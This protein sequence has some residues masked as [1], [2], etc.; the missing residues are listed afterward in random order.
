M[1]RQDDSRLPEPWQV[2]DYCCH[3][4]PPAE[5]PELPCIGELSSGDVKNLANEIS[6]RPADWSQGEKTISLFYV[7]APCFS[8]MWK[9]M[10][11]TLTLQSVS[12]VLGICFAECDPHGNFMYPVVL[13]GAVLPFAVGHLYLEL[14]CCGRSAIPFAQAVRQHKI[15]GVVCGFKVWFFYHLSS[16]CIYLAS[17]ASNSFT[18]GLW[19]RR[20][21]CGQHDPRQFDA[22][23]EIELRQSYFLWPIRNLPLAW[24]ILLV[25]ICAEI[26]L[27]WIAIEWWHERVPGDSQMRRTI[28]L[29]GPG[30]YFHPKGFVGS[31]QLFGS[32][33]DA[34]GMM[35]VGGQRLPLRMVYI[36]R[37]QQRYVRTFHGHTVAT[38]EGNSDLRRTL[39]GQ[40]R[41][42]FNEL[43][44]NIEAY[45]NA[46]RFR[47][48]FFG[49][50]RCCFPVNL[51]ITLYTIARAARTA[52]ESTDVKAIVSIVLG[53]M[54]AM[55]VIIEVVDCERMWREMRKTQVPIEAERADSSRL[56]DCRQMW[57]VRL[58]YILF[59]A[60]LIW[61]VAKFLDVFLLRQSHLESARPLR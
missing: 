9:A 49:V 38:Q 36:R 26:K 3:Q 53:L 47:I 13:W 5:V 35:I 42:H 20:P 48:I 34:A 21:P 17:V 24:I 52:D 23:V 44:Q 14:K 59:A 4:A 11:F 46:V 33:S 10:G 1:Q 37:N 58:A 54:S 40:N 31:G 39:T 57:A 60:L 15:C 28:D 27:V 56:G 7:A 16:S 45:F 25:W 43:M 12:F 51:Q 2:V 41:F 50:F 18:A 61:A 6:E 30:R 55:P 8:L 32:L 22:I 29:V 19:V